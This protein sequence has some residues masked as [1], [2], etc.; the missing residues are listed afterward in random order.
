MSPEA[1]RPSENELP[2]P[3]LKSLLRELQLTEQGVVFDYPANLDAILVFSG[4]SKPANV[5]RR[6][7]SKENT[8][9]VKEGVKDG[10]HCTANS[11]KRYP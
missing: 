1:S 2:E 7:S 8:S 9:V 6:H 4:M 3:I 5:Y 10:Y 11:I